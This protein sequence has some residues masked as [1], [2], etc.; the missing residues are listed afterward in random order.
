MA[1]SQLPLGAHSVH[2]SFITIKRTHLFVTENFCTPAHPPPSGLFVTR[3]NKRRP[4]SGKSFAVVNGSKKNSS[5]PRTD[6]HLIENNV[7]G[8]Q[9]PKE[10]HLHLVSGASTNQ[11]GELYLSESTFSH[12]YSRLSNLCPSSYT[13]TARLICNHSKKSCH[14]PIYRVGKPTKLKSDRNRCLTFGPCARLPL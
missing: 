11:S 3:S 4:K 10:I 5:T 14:Q 12:G 9:Y 8:N 6:L 13:A 1:L 7:V 2:K